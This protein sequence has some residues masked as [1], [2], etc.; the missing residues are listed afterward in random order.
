MTTPTLPIDRS[1]AWKAVKRLD[2]VILH[3]S[4]P[5]PAGSKTTITPA[6]CHRQHSTVFRVGSSEPIDDELPSMAVTF[7]LGRIDENVDRIVLQFE[8]GSY[9]IVLRELTAHAVTAE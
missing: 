5:L 7:D 2:T 1:A 6:P 9:A 3:G 4:L 8:D